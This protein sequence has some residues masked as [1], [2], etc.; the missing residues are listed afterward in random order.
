MS[1][2]WNHRL[3]EKCWIEREGDRTPVRVL[4]DEDGPCCVCGASTNWGVYQRG[5]P[6]LWPCKGK[7]PDEC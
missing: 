1:G 6:K 4:G 7:H 2:N 3:C 5:D